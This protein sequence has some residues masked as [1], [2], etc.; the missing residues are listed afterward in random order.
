[1]YGLEIVGVEARH[2]GPLIAE[3]ALRFHLRRKQG[4]PVHRDV[5]NR[6]ASRAETGATDARTD[7]VVRLIAEAGAPWLRVAVQGENRLEDHRLRLRFR[8][9]VVGEVWADAAFG[10]VR[11]ERLVVPPEDAAMEIPPKTAP[12][13]RYV[14]RFDERR[15]CTIF[16]DGLGEYEAADDGSIYVTLVRAV[17][18]L[19]VRD[20]PERPGNAGWPKPTPGAQCIREFA[21]SF[22]LMLHGPRTPETIDAIERAADDVLL[23][24]R[25]ATLRSAMRVPDAVVGVEL[26]G[27]GLA[28]SAI[29]ES[30]DGQ[31]V[32]LRCVNL[33]DAPVAGSWRLPFDVLEA[34]RARLDETITEALTTIDRVIAF[35]AAPREIVTILAR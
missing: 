7:I 2:D 28:V 31:W 32:V 17:G 1:L 27:I 24:L 30:E 33:I 12:L 13:H 9:D 10:P 22:A 23:P 34:Q 25:G 29:K 6:L 16:S 20:L 15:G 14:S 21:G 8:T 5:A 18:E 3:R 26:Q 19:S 11:R 4:A 35:E